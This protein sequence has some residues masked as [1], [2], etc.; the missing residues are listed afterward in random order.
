MFNAYLSLE[1]EKREK[2]DLGAINEQANRN[3]DLHSDG[4]FDGVCGLEPSLLQEQSYWSGYCAG[5][6][7]YWSKKLKVAIPTEF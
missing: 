3:T 2:Q 1:Q 4:L 6:R 5:L 7:K